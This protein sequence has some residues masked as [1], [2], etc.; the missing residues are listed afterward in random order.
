VSLDSLKAKVVLVDFWASWCGP[1]RKSFPWMSSLQE[2]Y[3]GKGLAIVAINL[4]K[5]R[6]AAE[7]FLEQNPAPFLIAFDP[8]GHVAEDF[9]VSA[10]PSS[11]LVGPGGKVLYSHAGFDPKQTAGMEEMIRKECGS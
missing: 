10:M 11:F 5:K 9:R 6:E 2:Q 4:D 3:G 7:E 8:S 1:C